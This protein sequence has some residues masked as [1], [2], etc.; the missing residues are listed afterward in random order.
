[1][2]KSLRAVITRPEARDGLDVAAN[3]N[4]LEPLYV[5]VQTCL[6]GLTLLGKSPC[7]EC[8][9]AGIKT[10]VEVTTVARAAAE[11]DTWRWRIK[12]RLDKAGVTPVPGWKAPDGSPVYDRRAVVAAATTNGPVAPTDVP[13][14]TVGEVLG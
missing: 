9:R 5:E 8:V 6:H 2:I 14:P 3:H 4:R 7:G 10:A 12:H 13:L 11:Y 1:M